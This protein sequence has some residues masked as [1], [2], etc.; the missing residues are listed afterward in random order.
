METIFRKNARMNKFPIARS[1]L[2]LKYVLLISVLKFNSNQLT[3][4]G[5]FRSSKQNLFG[6][7]VRTLLFCRRDD[8]VQSFILSHDTF[9]ELKEKLR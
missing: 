3:I 9:F 2:L 8:A 4:E 5:P 7:K 1:A 6:T